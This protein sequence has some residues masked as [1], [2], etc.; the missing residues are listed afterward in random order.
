MGGARYFL[1]IIDDFSKKV[2]LYVLKTKDQALSKFKEWCAEVENAINHKVKCLRIDNGL[3]FVSSEFNKFCISKAIK[4]HRTV[5]N[6]PQQ[7]GVVERMNRTILERVRCMLSSSGL[8]KKFWGETVVYLINRSTSVAKG[9][10]TPQEIW[11]GKK[12]DISHLRV[13]DCKAYSHI[14]KD[15]LEPRTLKCVILGYPKGTKGYKL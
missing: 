9:F 2:W 3:E 5:P 7:N 10:K 1:S 12:P 15:K 4:M 11:K 8:P 14:I 6:H 13:F